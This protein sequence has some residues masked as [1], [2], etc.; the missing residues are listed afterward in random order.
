MTRRNGNSSSAATMPERT[1]SRGHTTP[2]DA[3]AVVLDLDDELAL[4]QL[5]AQRDP[6][7]LGLT[8]RDPNVGGLEAVIDGIADH[9]R[10]RRP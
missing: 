7:G 3:G 2:V 1:R 8:R 4:T 6:R 5:G 9:V 10:E